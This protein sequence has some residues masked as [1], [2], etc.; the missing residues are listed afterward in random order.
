MRC[1]TGRTA[2]AAFG[3]VPAEPVASRQ[4]T[5]AALALLAVA[6]A[7]GLSFPLTKELLAQVGPADVLAQRYVIAA[8]ISGVLL[9]KWTRRLSARAWR[10]GVI[11]GVLYAVGGLLQVEGLAHTSASISGFTTGMYVVLT[12]V[13][14]FL[15]LKT[16]IRPVWW[17]GA[18][19]A[20]AGLAVMS[21]DGLGLGYGEAVTLVSALVYA[22][23][24]VGLS[25]WS[26]ARDALGLSVVQLAVTA[27]ICLL[28]AAP[29]GITLVS[30]TASWIG[31]AYLGLVSGALAMIAQSWGQAHLPSTRS[32]V[33]L[34]SEPV[35]A[36]ALS[37]GFFAEPL[38]ARILIGGAMMVAAML[39]VELA[40]RRPGDAPHAEN[41]PHLET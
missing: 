21:L 20:A 28:F 2:L 16:R 29:D 38:T 18:L 17:A 22:L 40:P 13:C 39:L 41:I 8:V 31:I 30:G 26:T 3:P 33:I 19:L 6:A 1:I 9:L 12:P 24:I 14:A 4:T 35:W 36:A 27:V 25:Q 34:V 7:W 37:I 23:H 32:A 15:L 10:D 11:L 5:M